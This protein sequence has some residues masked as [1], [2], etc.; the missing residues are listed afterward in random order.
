MQN[1]FTYGD[2]NPGPAG[3]SRPVRDGSS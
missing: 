2:Y 1:L 3:C